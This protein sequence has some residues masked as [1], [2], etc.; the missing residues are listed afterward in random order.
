MPFLGKDPQK[1]SLVLLED[2]WYKPYLKELNESVQDAVSE[3][4]DYA[5]TIKKAT[6]VNT[7]RDRNLL[8]E[9]QDQMSELET[10][11][12]VNNAFVLAHGPACP[13][14]YEYV[15]DYDTCLMAKKHFNVMGR[16]GVRMFQR[17]WSDSS[18]MGGCFFRR[19]H[20]KAHNILHF[21]NLQVQGDPAPKKG[22]EMM[23]C[24]RT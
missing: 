5:K 19:H 8:R 22:D 3:I 12:S 11:R 23:V 24:K 15:T 20:H 6:D 10:A 4:E 1:G 7:G 2:E 17:N 14:G 9:V 16:F 18:Y 21:N 13:A